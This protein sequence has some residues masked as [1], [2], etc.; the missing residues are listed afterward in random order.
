MQLYYFFNL[1]SITA[2]EKTTNEF[3]SKDDEFFKNQDESLK[4][5]EK[6][7]KKH[8]NDKL[9]KYA[10]AFIDE[11]GYL[12]IMFVDLDQN[13]MNNI[14]S[15]TENNKI[16]FKNAK[17]S[18]DELCQVRDQIV[19]NIECLS[20]NGVQLTRILMP[21]SENKIS[22]YIS[23]FDKDKENIFKKTI[24]SQAVE[25]FLEEEPLA[26]T[27][28]GGVT[29]GNKVNAYDSNIN[30]AGYGT[31]GFCAV[32]DDGKVGF[33][34][35]GNGY[36]LVGMNVAAAPGS[37]FSVFSKWTNIKS[38]LRLTSIYTGY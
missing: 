6:L 25:L 15:D 33:V 20:K 32:S 18:K 2:K 14:V 22:V 12:N 34:T 11:E 13:D 38:R 31:L 19:S 28:G 5:Y 24:N 27:N 10:G 7:M 8:E 23:E 1:T 21:D 17:Y 16:K 30:Y 3:V 29:S 36:L 9:Q 26:E 4:S 35:A 37:G